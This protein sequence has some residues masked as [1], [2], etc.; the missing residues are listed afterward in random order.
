AL[1]LSEALPSELTPPEDRGVIIITAQAQQGVSL[2]YLSRKIAPIEAALE[3]LRDGGEVS[4]VLSLIG[5]GASNRAFIIAS[6][7]PWEARGRS[8]Q[9]IQAALRPKVSRIPGLTVRLRSPNSLGIRGGGQGLSF[10]VTGQDYVAIAEAAEELAARLA[11][12]EGFTTSRLNFE[13]A[14]PQLSVEVDREAS[15]A[16]G[17]SIDSIATLVSTMVDD[18]VS[19]RVFVQDEIV[20]V[21][22]AGG[23][24]PVNDPGDLET[25]FVRTASGGYAPLSSFVTMTEEAVS[26]SLPREGRRRAATV[27]AGLEEG[28]SLGAATE[29]LREEAAEALEPP[30]ALTLLGEAAT[31]EESEAGLFLVFGF[32]LLIVLIVLAAQFESVISA[33]VIMATVPFGVA[34]AL[35]ALL[36]TGQS[37]NYYSQIGLVLLVG[38]MAKNGI[39]IVE[40]ANQRR[41]EGASAHDAALIAAE[42]RLRA[43]SMTAVS[44]VLGALPLILSSGPGAEAR[45]ALGWVVIGGL[46]FSTLF[47]LYLTPVAYS[48]LARLSA[49]KAEADARMRGELQAARG[50]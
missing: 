39:L 38:V 27:L 2:D 23:G 37:I 26:A 11:A 40:F 30:L 50:L 22:I 3:E 36:A 8:Q 19:A 33:L 10:A 43:V 35:Y 48:L 45:M 16:L 41:D 21:V 20:D 9:E 1:A 5:R 28:F 29:A 31:L 34:A 42:T 12:R 7:T 46:G 32:A 25:L 24:R 44:T 14:Q 18:R 15:T 47:T 49:P 6:L 13:T 4:N 17:A